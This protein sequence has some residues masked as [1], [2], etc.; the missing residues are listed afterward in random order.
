MRKRSQTL[1]HSLFGPDKVQKL[2]LA[3]QLQAAPALVGGLALGLLIVGRERL[4]TENN[5]FW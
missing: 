1:Y 2:M 3:Y 5:N 4:H